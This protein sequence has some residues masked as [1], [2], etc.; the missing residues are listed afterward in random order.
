MISP[1]QLQKI[2]IK[3]KS[4]NINNHITNQKNKKIIKKIE[5]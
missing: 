2:P 4:N 1:D 5:S 3:Q